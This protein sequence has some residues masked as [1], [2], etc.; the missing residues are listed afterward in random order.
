MSTPIRLVKNNGGTIDL[1]CTTLT[2]NVNRNVTPITMPFFGG[3]RLGFDLNLPSTVISMEGIIADDD[4]FTD[5]GAKAATAYID[6]G[7][8]V[9]PS[10]VFFSSFNFSTYGNILDII[11]DTTVNNANTANHGI[12]IAN[13]TNGTIFLTQQPTNFT[14]AT[15]DTDHSAGSGS[16][17]GSN[18]KI[19]R[20]DST[21]LLSVGMT[22]SGTG[23][24]TNSVITQIDSTTLFRVDLDTTATNN[25]QTL[26]FTGFY[27]FQGYLNQ[28]HWVGVYNSSTGVQRTPTEIATDFA[29][30]VNLRTSI[31]GMTATVTDSP[32]TGATSTAVKLQQTSV[33]NAGNTNYPSFSTWASV[34]DKPHHKQFNG[35]KNN[36]SAGGH[37]A[38]DRVAELYA[39]LCNSNNG[40]IGLGNIISGLGAAA[41]FMTTKGKTN[42]IAAGD[43]KYGD[44]IIGLQIPFTSKI[45]DNSSLFYMPTGAFKSV[46]D[47]TADM[48][49]PVGTEFTPYG[50]EYTGI[51]GAIAD[52]TFVQLGGE[53]IYSFTINFVPIDWII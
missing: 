29:A 4:K 51:K 27:G 9:A 46:D 23:I 19:I 26:T 44:Y 35:G 47:K 33:G 31:F 3:S 38:G 2:M 24:A 43:N 18:P 48:A 1:I 37:S 50:G 7:N 34:A 14:D 8:T 45:N 13:V 11:K 30:L 22:V 17:F 36:T 6:F 53:P 16:T 32:T 25:N 42:L 15:C 52:A 40:G 21:E 20:C 10:G 39:T 41:E 5:T 12:S 28:N 49:E